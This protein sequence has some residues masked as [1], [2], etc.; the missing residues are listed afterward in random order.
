MT[1]GPE[2]DPKDILPKAEEGLRASE[3]RFRL[4]AENCGDMLW[5]L[6]SI[7]GCF[8][9]VSDSVERLLSLPRESMTV[10]GLRDILSVADQDSVMGILHESLRLSGPEAKVPRVHVPLAHMRRADGSLVSTEM[11]VTMNV[12]PDG[13]C[14]EI[15]G[16]T[17]DIS[18]RLLLEQQLRQ[19]QKMDALGQLAG[20][21]AHDFNNLLQAIQGFAQLAN[22]AVDS[23]S[24]ARVHLQEVLHASQRARTLVAKLLA[25]GHR[26]VA[27]RVAVELD[28]LIA[29]LSDGMRRAIGESCR[30][31]TESEPGSKTVLVDTAQMEQAL[32]NLCLN[33]RDA[34]PGGGIVRLSTGVAHLDDEFCRRRPWA[35]TGD[36]ARLIVSDTGTGIPPDN[37]SR[38][39]E[40]FFT[41]KQRGRGTGMGLAMV[42]GIIQQHGGFIHAD[43]NLGTGTSFSI[44]LPLT[45][46]PLRRVEEEMVVVADPDPG[47][48][49]A[50]TIL[51]A[52]DDESVHEFTLRVER[53]ATACSR[54][55]MAL[56]R[57]GFSRRRATRWRSPSWTSSC[58]S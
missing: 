48:A 14:R 22:D 16:V 53:R 36:F 17:R 46:A 12:G 41:T 55:T 31:E 11:T 43:S 39:F 23:D 49:A 57:C 34:M 29:G 18:E 54:R 25:F 6:D 20:G 24:V 37:L 47:H 56:K 5:S 52:E 44:Y 35:R 50:E 40:P 27:P 2:T 45:P 21:V 30:L 1:N 9:F 28:G 8:T 58:R 33:A 38:I 15:F 4:M 3:T 26:G 19:A 10:R 42:Y 7:D 32:T 51:L 13:T